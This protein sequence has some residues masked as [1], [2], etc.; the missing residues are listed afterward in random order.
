MQ[1][2]LELAVQLIVESVVSTPVRAAESA[3]IASVCEWCRSAPHRFAHQL[4]QRMDAARC[5]WSR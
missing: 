5:R 4:D 2:L 3:E 1:L